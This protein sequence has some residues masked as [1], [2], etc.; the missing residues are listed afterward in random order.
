MAKA[1]IPTKGCLSGNMLLVPGSDYYLLPKTPLSSESK[2]SEYNKASSANTQHLLIKPRISQTRKQVTRTILGIIKEFQNK[3]KKTL[4]FRKYWRSLC[5]K[6]MLLRK[7]QKR[8]IP[9]SK[10]KKVMLRVLF[11]HFKSFISITLSHSKRPPQM[12][13][14][15]PWFAP[16]FCSNIPLT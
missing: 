7:H 9:Y 4:M 5:L 15:R 8:A 14:L 13:S 2:V 10:E 3:A 1:A 6:I 16:C 12:S 11:L